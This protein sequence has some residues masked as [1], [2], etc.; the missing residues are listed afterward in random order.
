MVVEKKLGAQCAGAVFVD[1]IGWKE[2]GK[3]LGAQC[4]FRKA[5]KNVD[6]WRFMQSFS[7]ETLDHKNTPFA[8]L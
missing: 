4:D 2:E 6:W 8:L 7:H 5:K 1:G 3:T